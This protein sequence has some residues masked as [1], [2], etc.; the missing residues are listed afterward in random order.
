MRKEGD[1]RKDTVIKEE[2]FWE[3]IAPHYNVLVA[4]D[5]RPCVVDMWHDVGIPNVI[6]VADQR[7]KF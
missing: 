2:L 1:V 6:A 7:N 3:H 4:F 5:D